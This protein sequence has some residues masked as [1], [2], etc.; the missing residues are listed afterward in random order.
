MKTY[1]FVYDKRLQISIPRLHQAWEKYNEVERAEILDKWEMMR[2]RIPDQI[3][4]FEAVINRK[5][6]EL[7]EEDNFKQSCAINSQIAEYASRINDLHLWYRLN[8][9]FSADKSHQ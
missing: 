1:E 3:K 4:S 7:N 5:Q 9:D 8:Q 6:G 2:G